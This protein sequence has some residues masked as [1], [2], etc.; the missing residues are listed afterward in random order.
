M[1]DV[2]GYEDMYSVDGAGIVYSHLKRNIYALTQTL[3]HDG[4][5]CVTL[6]KP[7]KDRKTFRVHRLVVM[8]YFDFDSILD[9]NHKDGNKSNNSVYNLEMIS[10]KD[11]IRH[12]I[13]LG[14]RGIYGNN[15]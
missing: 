1:I 12:A 9:V 4:Y 11:N 15:R 6:T 13:G 7:I 14:L 8:C 5:S 2:P 3:N 10:R